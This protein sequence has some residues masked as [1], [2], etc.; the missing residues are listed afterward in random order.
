MKTAGLIRKGRRGSKYGSQIQQN[1]VWQSDSDEQNIKTYFPTSAK[2][3]HNATYIRW[4]NTGISFAHLITVPRTL[5]LPNITS[6]TLGANE[7]GG[8]IT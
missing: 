4:T 1:V 7:I 5:E 2:Q 3:S 6:D 8:G